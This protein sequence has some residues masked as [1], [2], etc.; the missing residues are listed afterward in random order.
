MFTGLRTVEQVTVVTFWPPTG[1]F[2]D[3]EKMGSVLYA[4]NSSGVAKCTLHE[5]P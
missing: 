5:M 1:R 2:F 4:I 3:G